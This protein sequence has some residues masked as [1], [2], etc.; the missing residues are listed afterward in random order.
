MSK[1]E[2]TIRDVTEEG[3][4]PV[5]VVEL[6]GS[7]DPGTIGDLQ[8]M[9]EDL[10]AADRTRVALDLE[11]LK[12]INSTGMGIMV[13]YVDTFRARGGGM[14]LMNV[15][16]KVLLV[17]E[18]LGLQELFRIVG[19]QG[20][21]VRALHGESVGPSSVQVRMDEGE[22]LEAEA[23]EL[24]ALEAEAV[25]AQPLPAAAEPVAETGGGELVCEVCAARLGYAGPGAYRC[26]RCGTAFRLETDYS[27]TFYPETDGG[28][29]LTLPRREALLVA[30]G[31]L[32]EAAGRAH[33][34]NE[35]PAR[36]LGEAAGGCLRLL[37]DEALADAPPSQRLHL[38]VRAFDEG[39]RVRIFAG[40][41]PLEE[42]R[43]A[44]WREGVAALEIESMEDGQLV[45]LEGR[46]DAAQ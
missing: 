34:L 28:V 6:E 33:G 8:Q 22:P 23:V 16:P 35:E 10:L 46:P 20:E 3:T 37:A 7:V 32:V 2:T 31:G 13:Q 29:E 1:L 41:A 26:P 36:L 27:V 17:V 38:Y 42:G 11:K 18:M 19:G 39:V 4:D 30:A 45:T 40:G 14:V 9:F 12:Y 25:D 43:F 24:D 44:S 21:A 15:Q 5:T